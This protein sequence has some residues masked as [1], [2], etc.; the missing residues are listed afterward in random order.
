MWFDDIYF[1]QSM[2]V[3]VIFVLDHS[4]QC[5]GIPEAPHLKLLGE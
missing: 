4:S 2:E 3:V 1:A 5:E